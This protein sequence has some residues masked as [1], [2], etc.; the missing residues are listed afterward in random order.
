MSSI[1]SWD[2][3]QAEAKGKN[4]L[5]GLSGGSLRVKKINEIAKLTDSDDPKSRT[6]DQRAIR[7]GIDAVE[8]MMRPVEKLKRS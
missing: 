5:F 8:R 4:W 3:V 2:Y 7:N 1:Q 6:Y